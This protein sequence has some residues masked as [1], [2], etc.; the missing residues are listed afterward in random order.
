[1]RNSSAWT[2]RLFWLVLWAGRTVILAVV[3]P[4]DSFRLSSLRE[5]AIVLFGCDCSQPIPSRS[6][7][8]ANREQL[9]RVIGH[10]SCRFIWCEFL[11]VKATPFRASCGLTPSLLAEA[12]AS[13]VRHELAETGGI[14]SCSR[15]LRS[16]NRDESW[17][18]VSSLLR[19][20]WMTPSGRV[21]YNTFGLGGG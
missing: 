21:A 19:C 18:S 17:S 10:G 13:T 5:I 15:Q 16:N 4:G 8:H 11:T 20:R 3:T 6:T 12:T 14:S 2:S 7:T 1:M 9:C